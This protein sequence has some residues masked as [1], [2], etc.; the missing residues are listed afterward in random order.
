[1]PRSSR[2]DV[3]EGVPELAGAHFTARYL[4]ADDLGEQTYLFVGGAVRLEGCGRREPGSDQT[5]LQLG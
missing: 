1:M 2:I 5:Q 4:F 3:Q